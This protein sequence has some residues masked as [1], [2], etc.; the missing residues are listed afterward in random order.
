M[1][2]VLGMDEPGDNPDWGLGSWPPDTWES[3]LHVHDP[4]SQAYNDTGLS[5]DLGW[6]MGGTTTGMGTRT[7]TPRMQESAERSG[8]VV[9]N[10]A[11]VDRIRHA[12]PV[13]LG[14]KR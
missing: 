13:S 1:T 2:P 14:E 7:S 4:L 9:A 10:Q 12:F 11:L 5:N 8:E 6:R 3:L